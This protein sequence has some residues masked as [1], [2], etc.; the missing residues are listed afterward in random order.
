MGAEA[1]RARAVFNSEPGR[2]SGNVV[3]GRKGGVFMKMAITGK[4]AHSGGYFSDG[5]SAIEELARKTIALHAITD[6]PRGT[7]V[8][9]GLVSGGQT[10]KPA[11]PWARGEL[12]L[13]SH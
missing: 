5:I 6:L 1:R 13:R 8:N 12:D 4:A 3:N 11:A 2:P 7:T 10:G 9:V